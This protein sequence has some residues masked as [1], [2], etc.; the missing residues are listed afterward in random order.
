MS[1]EYHSEEGTLKCHLNITAKKAHF[2]SLQWRRE[3]LQSITDNVPSSPLVREI[4][5]VRDNLPPS[6]LCI[7]RCASFA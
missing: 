4:M 1:F 2:K 3:H 7:R 6:L 5:S